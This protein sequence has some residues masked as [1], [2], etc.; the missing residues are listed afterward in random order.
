MG[1]QYAELNIVCL[2]FGCVLLFDLLSLDNW[3]T[4]QWSSSQFIHMF[5]RGTHMEILKVPRYRK[6]DVYVFFDFETSLGIKPYRVNIV[7]C[8]DPLFRD[9]VVKQAIR[10]SVYLWCHNYT[11]TNI[12]HTASF[13]RPIS[14][15]FSFKLYQQHNRKQYLHC[16]VCYWMSRSQCVNCIC[17]IN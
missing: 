16:W 10:T 12:S 11:V 5:I 1:A 8:I 2:A 13:T 3:K 9:C 6:W 14:L 4:K 7:K 17:F 15:F